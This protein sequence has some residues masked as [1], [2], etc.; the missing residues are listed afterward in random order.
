MFTCDAVRGTVRLP[1]EGFAE[2]VLHCS[3]PAMDLRSADLAW[4]ATG[5]G[6]AEATAGDLAIR[7]SVDDGVFQACL[8]NRGARPVRLDDIRVTFP[9]T[10]SVDDYL[11]LVLPFNMVEAGGVKV[12]GL[13]TPSLANLAESGMATV[14]RNHRTGE[15]LLVG[16]LPSDSGDYVYFSTSHNAGHLEDRFGLAIR[17]EFRCDIPP[18]GSVRTSPLTA[19]VGTDGWQMLRDYA[20]RCAERLAL[21]R[22]LKPREAGWNSW[23]YYD[24]AV[25]E[26]D[27]LENAAAAADLTDSPRIV[28]DE[29]WE[30]RWGVWQA[31]WKF[32]SGLEGLARR[33]AD[34]G[35]RPGIWTAPLM[36]NCYTKFHREHPGWFARDGRGELLKRDHPYGPMGVLDPTVPAV[37]DWLTDTFAGLRA[38]GFDYF[39][40]DFTQELLCASRFADPTVPRGRQIRLAFEA[41]RE[42]I[43][44]EAYLLAC[45]APQSAI[46]GLADA[47]RIA[48][49]IH[50]QWSHIRKNAAAILSLAWM[51]GRLLNVDPDFLVMRCV[52]LADGPLDRPFTRI[53]PDPAD[54][55]RTGRDARLAGMK[56][57]ALLVLLAGGDVILGDRLRQL[58]PE[59]LRLL[60][61]VLDS[62]LDEPARPLD[63]MSAH[64]R[65][66]RLWVGRRGSR[67][68]LIVFNFSE[69][70]DE[71]QIEPASLGLAGAMTD[72]W[73]DGPAELDDGVLRATLPRRSALACWVDA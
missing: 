17:C 10:L 61:R 5:P 50:I 63:F 49:D 1:L 66:P 14:L 25:E 29:G 36:V 9:A 37:R 68:L 72:F 52:E 69:M 31:N 43:G 28:I 34:L 65:L 27:V 67:R 20:A 70:P 7:L 39:K 60:R 8:E 40:V 12:P 38:A 73:T 48:G 47:S 54:G 56:V 46:L 22:P 62:Q 16:A 59:G 23:D 24:G 19:A 4:S 3:G 55:W 71:F 64:G 33:I 18:G 44:P 35:G 58:N 32:P 15:S 21:P 30:P 13:A 51:Q 45:G 41:I 57:Q 6:S 26:Q 2:A 42:G 53:P 11:E